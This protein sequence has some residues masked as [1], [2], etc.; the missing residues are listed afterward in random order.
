[1]HVQTNSYALT[2]DYGFPVTNVMR[3]KPQEALMVAPPLVV[4]KDMGFRTTSVK[5]PNE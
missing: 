4:S 3:L 1:M 5:H 2:G